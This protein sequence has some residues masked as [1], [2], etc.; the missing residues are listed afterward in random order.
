MDTKVGQ[1]I[2]D[3]IGSGLSTALGGGRPLS[4]SMGPVAMEKGTTTVME[5]Y[6]APKVNKNETISIP[7]VVATV[8]EPDGMSRDGNYEKIDQAF[9]DRNQ[10]LIL[11]KL[12]LG[13][14]PR[15]DD[16]FYVGRGQ[17]S[18]FFDQTNF[19][20]EYIEGGIVKLTTTLICDLRPMLSQVRGMRYRLEST[21][22]GVA[23]KA[24]K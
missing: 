22:W 5:S 8:V 11:Q 4:E 17:G 15:G 10:N 18:I 12:V 19:K 7:V 2:L 1:S 20:L 6:G 9:L 23:E 16:S 13:L 14:N 24:S 21:I 3:S